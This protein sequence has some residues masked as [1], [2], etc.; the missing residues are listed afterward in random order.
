MRI[1]M[2]FSLIAVVMMAAMASCGMCKI[3]TVHVSA[4]GASSSQSCQREGSRMY[5]PSLE[6]LQNVDDSILILVSGSQLPLRKTLTFENLTDIAIVGHSK[7]KIIIT[8]EKN[9][10]SGITFRFVRNITISNL[11]FV[12]CGA[13][14]DSTSHNR[15][16]NHEIQNHTVPAAVYRCFH[17]QC[18][19]YLQQWHWSSLLW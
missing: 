5:C 16:F 6:A 18:G 11:T 1:I 8:C 15:K 9:A 4:E 10:S 19:H 2:K 13:L 3:T 12:H 17:H 7:D 14:H